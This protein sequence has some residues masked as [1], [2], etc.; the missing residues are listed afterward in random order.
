[1]LEVS[2]KVKKNIEELYE[3]WCWDMYEN[4]GFDHALDAM[5]VAMQ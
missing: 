3:L 1:M 2:M 5:R 4:C